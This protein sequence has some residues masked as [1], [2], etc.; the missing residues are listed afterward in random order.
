MVIAKNL[1]EI[2]NVT[3]HIWNYLECISKAASSVQNDKD[4]V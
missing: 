4:C 2:M 3:G 1:K